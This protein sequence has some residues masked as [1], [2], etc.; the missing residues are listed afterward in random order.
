MDPVWILCTSDDGDE[1][2]LNLSRA[3]I[4]ERH[5][6]GTRVRFSGD[7]RDYIDVKETPD[8]IA[9]SAGLDRRVGLAE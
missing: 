9:A 3:T 5:K 1:L 7:G 4:I 6:K 8:E 2:R